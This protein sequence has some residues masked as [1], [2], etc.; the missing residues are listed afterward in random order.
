MGCLVAVVTLQWGTGAR[1]TSVLLAQ[2]ST[3]L[4]VPLCAILLLVLTSSRAIMGDLKSKTPT[5][6]V[7]TAGLLILL[8]LAGWTF[9]GLAA[10][11]TG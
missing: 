8:G 11:L 1:T 10:K 7:G 2:A 9:M 4:A 5:I 6:I 3:L